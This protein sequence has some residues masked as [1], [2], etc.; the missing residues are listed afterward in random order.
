MPSLILVSVPGGND[1][2]VT[3]QNFFDRTRLALIATFEDKTMSKESD[4]FAFINIA[5]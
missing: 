1:I 2:S 5:F 3:L 4:L